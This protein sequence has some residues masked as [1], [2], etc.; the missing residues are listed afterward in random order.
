MTQTAER[1]LELME[2]HGDSARALEKGAGLPISTITSWKSNRFKPS[3]DTVVKVAQYYNV[4]TD[5]LLCLTDNPIPPNQLDNNKQSNPFLS[6]NLAELIYE[7]RF[8]N[9]AKLYKAL[10]DKQR[11]QVYGVVQG[12]TIGLGL[13]INKILGR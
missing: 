8:I 11:E 3:A 7:Q 12:I 10:P 13:D 1:I 2:Q 6:T 5:Y 9:T 4:S